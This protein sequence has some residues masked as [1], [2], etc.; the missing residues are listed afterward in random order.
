MKKYM[1]LVE[2]M[3]ECSDLYNETGNRKY[4]EED[5]C[6]THVFEAETLQL[7]EKIMETAKKNGYN[8]IFDIGCAMGHQSEAFIGT[9]VEYVGINDGKH[10]FWNEG[11]FE[12]IIGEY[13]IK[14]QGD[15]LAVSVLCLT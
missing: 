6:I 14:L 2:R 12:Y 3:K 10:E 13:P 15:G 9:G 5:Y 8:K 7:Y 1:K 11:R 4:M